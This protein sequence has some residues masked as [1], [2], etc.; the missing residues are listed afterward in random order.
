MSR[1]DRAVDDGI[2]EE[3]TQNRD[4]RGI[5]DPRLLRQVRV[6]QWHLGI[7]VMVVIPVPVYAD[8]GAANVSRQAVASREVP[9]SR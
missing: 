2:R 3:A 7:Q 9:D 1:A 4:E 6:L 5:H 8:E